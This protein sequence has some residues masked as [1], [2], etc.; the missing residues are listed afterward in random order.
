MIDPRKISPRSLRHSTSKRLC[1]SFTTSTL[2]LVWALSS[3]AQDPPPAEV[4]AAETTDAAPEPTAVV[5]PAPEPTPQPE[6][7]VEEAGAFPGKRAARQRHARMDRAADLD[8]RED[9]L[10]FGH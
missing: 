3:A 10:V 1:T 8:P 5:E 2:I 7:V 9:I 4:P 6:P